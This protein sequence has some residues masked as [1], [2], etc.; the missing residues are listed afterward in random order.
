MGATRTYDPAEH[1]VSFL[2]NILT[3]FGPDSF[4]EAERNEEAFTLTV[5]A[6]GEPARARNRN[7]SGR[8]TITLLATSP[9]NDLLS[10]AMLLDEIAGEG[11]GPLFLKDQ[12]GTMVVHAESAWIVKA[13][14]ISRAKEVPV[15]VWIIECA[16]MEVF[17]GGTLR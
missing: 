3:A 5:G 7:I 6:G 8:V 4:I 16:K 13:P 12:G 10:N 17:A 2:G 14:A 15:Y 11:I 9:E 1:L